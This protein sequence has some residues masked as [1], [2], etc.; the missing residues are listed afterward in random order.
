MRELL[1]QRATHEQA[2]QTALAAVTAR[3]A[4]AT[5]T[6]A[7][8]NALRAARQALVDTDTALDEQQTALRSALEE[9][10]RNA[11]AAAMRAELGQ[12]DGQR[13]VGGARI[14]QEQRTYT[15]ERDRRGETSFFVDAFRSQTGDV[16]AQDRLRRH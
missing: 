12:G 15:A 9:Q 13:G 10:T 14:G 6:E 4:D 8:A 16:Q 11:N 2:V 7:E 1:D 3:G 5:P